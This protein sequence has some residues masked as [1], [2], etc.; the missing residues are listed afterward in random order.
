MP[1]QPTVLWAQ[2]SDR[3]FITIDL[4]DCKDPKVTL[5]GEGEHGKLSFRGHAHSHATGDQVARMPGR[6]MGANRRAWKPLL[7][8]GRVVHGRQRVLALHSCRRA[9]AQCAAQTGVAAGGHQLR[10]SPG[11]TLALRTRPVARP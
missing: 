6:M 7:E 9:R 2:R 5:D 10:C 1:L 11:L 8:A 3:L 4:Q